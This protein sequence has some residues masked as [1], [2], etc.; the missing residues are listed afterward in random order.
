MVDVAVW[1][2]GTARAAGVAEAREAEARVVEAG[3]EARAAGLE[4]PWAGLEARAAGLEAPWAGLEAPAA[5]WAGSVVAG[6]RPQARP[7]RIENG[8]TRRT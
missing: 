6:A 8:S 2:V 7:G 4:A 1:T 3:E 5:A